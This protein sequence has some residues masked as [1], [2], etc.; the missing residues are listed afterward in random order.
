M[1]YSTL[2]ISGSIHQ[3]HE[4]FSD[5]ARGR[6]CSFMSFSALLCAQSCPVQQW[7][8]CTV[9]Q[10]LTHGDTIYLT[11]LQRQTIPDTE[12]MSLNYLPDRARSF[13]QGNINHGEHENEAPYCTLHSALMNTFSNNNYVT[14]EY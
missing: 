14:I 1:S 2:F 4:Q 9:D 10:I 8:T 12:T 7:K 6:Q 13:Y 5:I 11:A 3:G